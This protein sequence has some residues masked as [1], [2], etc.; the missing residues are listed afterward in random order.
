[1][2]RRIEPELGPIGITLDVDMN[3]FVPIRRIEEQPLRPFLEYG[4]HGS[5]CN[6]FPAAAF[7]RC[8]R[9]TQITR[10]LSRRPFVRPANAGHQARLKAEAQ[11]P[12]EA[13]ACM[14]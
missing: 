5:Q 7:D 13:V 12:L 2:N 6:A 14:P 10:T 4:R 8:S 9:T 11:R 1:M 3:R